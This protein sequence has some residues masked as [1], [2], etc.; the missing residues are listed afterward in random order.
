VHLQHLTGSHSS[1]TK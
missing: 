1:R